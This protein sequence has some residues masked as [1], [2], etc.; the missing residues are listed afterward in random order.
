MILAFANDSTVV[1]L[2]SEAQANVVCE[3]AD[4]LDGSWRLLDA[5]GFVLRAVVGPR[6]RRRFFGMTISVGTETFTLEPTNERCDE[7]VRRLRSGDITVSRGPTHIDS[8][9][10]L[11]QRLPELF[12]AAK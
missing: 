2:A 9:E 12:S 1:V 5:R 7:L 10:E 4:V 8:I 6:R 11:T 3:T